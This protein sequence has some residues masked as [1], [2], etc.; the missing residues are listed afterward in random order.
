M[1][2]LKLPDGKRIAVNLGVDVDLSLYGL[3]DLIDHRHPLCHVEN[4][5]RKLACRG[6]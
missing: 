6:F 2:Y 1:G 4:L 3:A 5:V